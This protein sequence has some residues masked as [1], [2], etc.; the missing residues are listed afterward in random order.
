MALLRPLD[1]FDV[2]FESRDLTPERDRL[3]EEHGHRKAFEV[4]A[5]D[6]ID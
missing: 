5:C 4:A 6:F 2:T 3:Q 1:L